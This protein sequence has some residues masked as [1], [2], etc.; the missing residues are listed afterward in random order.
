MQKE[1]KHWTDEED[2]RLKEL[3]EA[4]HPFSKCAEI[5]GRSTNSIAGRCSRLN[6]CKSVNTPRDDL[7]MKRIVARKKAV[8]TP[9]PVISKPPTQKVISDITELTNNQCRWPIGDVGNEDFHFC[10]QTKEDG[11]SYC[12]KH[13]AVAYVKPRKTYI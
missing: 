5:L 6:L 2:Q 9:K 13:N 12:S 1:M 4:G 10:S 8:T 3:R 11:S 7:V